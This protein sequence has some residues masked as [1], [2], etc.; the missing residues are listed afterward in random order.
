LR[1]L[2]DFEISFGRVEAQQWCVLHSTLPWREG[3]V[4]ALYGDWVNLDADQYQGEH[5][6]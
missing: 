1:Q 2:A 6:V 5:Y 3:K 4:L